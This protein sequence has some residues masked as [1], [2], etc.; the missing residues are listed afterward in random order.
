MPAFR[1]PSLLT[2]LLLLASFATAESALAHA[3]LK[4]EAPAAD[5]TVVA[6]AEVRL[7]FSEGIEEKFSKVTLTRNGEAIAVKSVTT[8]ASD[9][10]VLIVTPEQPLA[11]GDYE[12][13]WEVLSVDTHKSDGRY[14][15]KVGN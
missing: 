7:N 4:S 2:T 11:A 5:S 13:K 6:P 1:A 15:F 9:K 8:D 14:G 12:V 10:K 3:H